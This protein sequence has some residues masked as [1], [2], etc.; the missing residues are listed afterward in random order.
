MYLIYLFYNFFF[1]QIETNNKLKT[2]EILKPAF[3]RICQTA[4]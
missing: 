4:H 3:D 2:P 1:L